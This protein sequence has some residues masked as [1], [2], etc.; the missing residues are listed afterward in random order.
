MNA[1]TLYN[2]IIDLEDEATTVRN[3]HLALTETIKD[4]RAM[5]PQCSICGRSVPEPCS[6]HN[7]QEAGVWDH[8]C[9][10]SLTPHP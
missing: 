8:Y 7:Y 1:I 3:L 4:L 9:R 10:D 5:L 6:A 2:K